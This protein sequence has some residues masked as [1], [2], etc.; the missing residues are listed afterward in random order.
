MEYF[1]YVMTNNPNGSLYIG[2]TN[3]LI[4]RVYE[5]KSG[6][7]DGFTK[8]YKIKILVYFEIHQY[9]ENAIQREKNLKHWK[10]EWKI[11]L[12]EEHNPHWE[13]LWEKIW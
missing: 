11:Q 7:V 1:V 9:I 5:H 6:V 2:V 10:R 3:N 8:K 4:R 13:D 12:I